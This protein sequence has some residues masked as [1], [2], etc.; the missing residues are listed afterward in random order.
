[1]SR[2]LM[3]N[4]LMLMFTNMIVNLILLIMGAFFLWNLINFKITSTSLMN[5]LMIMILS[6]MVVWYSCCFNMVRFRNSYLLLNF[7]LLFMLMFWSL[8]L[9][10]WMVYWRFFQIYFSLDFLNF[11]FNVLNFFNLLNFRLNWL[12][13][14][15]L[16]SLLF[17]RFN[18]F[19]L[20]ILVFNWLSFINIVS[21]FLYVLIFWLNVLYLNLFLNLLI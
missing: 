4:F 9:F 17:N 16:F 5:W 1:M 20:I 7:L 15:N 3:G 18:F 12:D 10:N 8:V 11:W 21:N 19:N 14:L 13:F 2:C 6:L